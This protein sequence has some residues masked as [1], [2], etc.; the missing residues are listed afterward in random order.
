MPYLCNL[1]TPVEQPLGAELVPVAPH[2]LQQ[3]AVS[4]ELGDE[5]QAVPG[6]NT[7]GL[8][9]VNVVQASH[10][11]HVLWKLFTLDFTWCIL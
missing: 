2:V 7:Q 5:L 4:A 1:D 9:N 3:G 6:T 8:S 11:H 10:R